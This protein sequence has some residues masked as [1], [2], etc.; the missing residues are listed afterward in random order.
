MIVPLGGSPD[1][2]AIMLA[3]QQTELVKGGQALKT[4]AEVILGKP[5]NPYDFDWGIQILREAKFIQLDNRNVY[6][7]TE[8]GKI[9]ALI[10]EGPFHRTRETLATNRQIGQL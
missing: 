4:Q 2:I 6:R 9:A 8:H 10:A 1:R 3:L 5:I 7:T